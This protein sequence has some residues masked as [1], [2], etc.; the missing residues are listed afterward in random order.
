ME[1]RKEKKT[2]LSYIWN[3]VISLQV[4][5]DNGKK[6]RNKPQKVINYLQKNIS[7]KTYIKNTQNS[8]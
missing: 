7:D 2:I 6:W 1:R 8:I 3:E 5:K 4:K